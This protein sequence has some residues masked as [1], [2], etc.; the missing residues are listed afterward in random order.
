MNLLTQPD[1]AGWG[2]AR[3]E[4]VRQQQC[5]GVGVMLHFNKHVEEYMNS[6]LLDPKFSVFTTANEELAYNAWFS[7]ELEQR[8]SDKRPLF[9]HVLA[10]T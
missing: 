6:P 3:L 4:R 9:S 10:S 2:Y 1:Y 5:G 8:A 7:E